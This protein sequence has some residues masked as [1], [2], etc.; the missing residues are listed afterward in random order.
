MRCSWMIVSLLVSSPLAQSGPTVARAQTPDPPKPV[1]LTLPFTS[2]LDAAREILRKLPDPSFTVAGPAAGERRSTTDSAPMPV[3]SQ[4]S[5]EAVRAARA[6]ANPAWAALK[7]FRE[8]SS[9]ADREGA[10]A[11]LEMAWMLD[12]TI[13]VRG[14]AD[15][16]YEGGLIALDRS[17]APAALAD[18]T[19]ALR[20]DPTRADVYHGRALALVRLGQY[21]RARADLDVAVGLDPG[22]VW[23]LCERARFGVL[24][25]EHRAAIVDFDAALRLDPSLIDAYRGRAEAHSKVGNSDALEADLSELIRLAPSDPA[26]RGRRGEIRENRFA[27]IDAIDDYTAALRLDPLSPVLYGRRAL[28]RTK[29]GDQ[30]GAIADADDA[31]RLDS[32]LALASFARA[33]GRR[34]R[35]DHAGAVADLDAVLQAAPKSVDA[36]SIRAQL[37]AR[38]Y[39]YRVRDGQKALESATLACTLS[40]R[41]SRD[42]LLALAAAHAELGNFPAAIAERF[43]AAARRDV[44][45]SW[46]LDAHDLLAYFGGVVPREQP[47]DDRPRQNRQ[48]S[49]GVGAYWTDGSRVHYYYVDLKVLPTISLRWGRLLA[50]P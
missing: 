48:V 49:C 28:C 19:R 6:K 2:G 4:F 20:F 37:L 5:I 29:S 43:A 7:R 17:D 33:L 9:S 45:S 1:V 21:D 42:A 12:P 30:V 10:R 25:G 3:E 16:R 8:R 44:F 35:G 41:R 46:L 27:F 15:Y 50:L 40:G 14:R 13:V 47:P 24:R 22:N 32:N 23:F 34:A 38:S 36:L 18:F 11:S 39:D 31:L 26:V